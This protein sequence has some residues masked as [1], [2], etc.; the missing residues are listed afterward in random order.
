MQDRLETFLRGRLG[1]QAPVTHRWAGV[2]SYTTSGLPIVEQ[3]ESGVWAVGGYNGTGNVVGAICGRGVA[4][5]VARG[6]SELLMGLAVCN[7]G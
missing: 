4:Q 2:V 5:L 7:A 6:E 3:V 1:V